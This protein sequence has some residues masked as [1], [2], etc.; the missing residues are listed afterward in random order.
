MAEIFP[1][2]KTFVD[3]K[4]KRP[5]NVTIKRF[6]AFMKQHNNE[7]SKDD[8]RRFVIVSFFQLGLDLVFSYS[9]KRSGKV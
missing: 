8:V 3:M 1:D 7:P 4:L 9:S 2:S 6:H 5:A